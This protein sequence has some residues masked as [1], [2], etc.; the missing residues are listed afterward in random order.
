MLSIYGHK[1]H[2]HLGQAVDENGFLTDA[3][4]TWQAG[5]AG[6][7]VGHIKHGFDVLILKAYE[8]PPSLPEFRKICAT[9]SDAL[10]VEQI[11][12]ILA[13]SVP[14]QGGIASRYQHPMVFAVAKS[15]GFD[16][17]LFKTS[18]TKQ[19]VEMVRPIYE[20]LV[21]SGWDEFLPEHYE[22]QKAIAKPLK[23]TS[24]LGL[25]VLSELKADLGL[26]N[27]CPSKEIV[28][29]KEEIKQDIMA[30]NRETQAHKRDIL[31][32]AKQQIEVVK[33]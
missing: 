21:Q 28:A 18:S 26:V 11:V 30:R 24:G 6:M 4:K 16:S 17:F 19:C 23:Q 9:Q 5:L 20:H 12:N 32:N 13:N 7:T 33:Q 27:D 8:W 3:A 14:R 15:E 10:P 22:E 1:W 25:S 29:T 31:A 2:S